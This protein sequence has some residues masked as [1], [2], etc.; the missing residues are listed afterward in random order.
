V[1]P[2]DATVLAPW[3]RA[4]TRWLRAAYLNE[5]LKTVGD[6]HFLPAAAAERTLLLEFYQLEK[7]IYEIRYE[8]NN[9]P[10]WLAIPLAGLREI[11]GQE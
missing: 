2:E 5:Y 9:R 7:C 4:W 10:D 11:L 8:L 3:A 1:R 6:A